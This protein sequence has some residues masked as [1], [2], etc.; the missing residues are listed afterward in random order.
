[1][2][3]VQVMEEVGGEGVRNAPRG[4]GPDQALERMRLRARLRKRL[5]VR[6]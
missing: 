1:M 6:V 5:A 4:V 2:Y 3:E